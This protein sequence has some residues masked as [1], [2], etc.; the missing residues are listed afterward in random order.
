MIFNI[1]QAKTHPKR[2]VKSLLINPFARKSRE[3]FEIV[4]KFCLTI[5][6][7]GTTKMK[8]TGLKTKVRLYT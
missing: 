3:G 2:W 1:L 7:G 6:D 4:K 8:K 5:R